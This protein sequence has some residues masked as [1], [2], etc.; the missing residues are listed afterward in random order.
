MIR[1]KVRRLR[2]EKEE[3]EGQKLTYEVLTQQT[4]LAPSTLARML[5]TDPVERV[6]GKT[7]SALCR[8]FECDLCDLLEYVPDDLTAEV[9]A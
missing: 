8:F 4:G 9:A 1:S 3:R 5:G 2:F 7:L 6:D